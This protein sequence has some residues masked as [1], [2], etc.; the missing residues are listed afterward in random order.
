MKP[1]K[2][3]QDHVA[4]FLLGSRV[5]PKGLVELQRY[6]RC[7]DP[8]HFTYHKEESGIVAVSDNFRYGSIITSG[9][10][11]ADLDRNIKDAILTAFDIPS[12]Y[13]KEAG[14]QRVGEKV[15]EY[16]AA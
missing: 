12:A 5:V 15:M 3:F 6:F 10:N 7:Y 2:V 16:A 4:K 9:Q 1:L 13:A 11:E 8:L 14:V